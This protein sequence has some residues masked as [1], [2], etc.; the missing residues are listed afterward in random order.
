MNEF[1]KII[2]GFVAAAALILF[3]GAL[4][5]IAGIISGWIVGLFFSGI[6]LE[7][8]ARFGVD[9]A[10]LAVWQ[11]GGLLGFIGAFFKSV[12]TNATAK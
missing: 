12:Q 5:V 11:L 1:L 10:G 7:T 3:L 2:G 4:G 6:I 8:L 9:T